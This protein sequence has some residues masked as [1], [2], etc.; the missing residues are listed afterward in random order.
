MPLT[1]SFDWKT[2][3]GINQTFAVDSV[4][5]GKYFNHSLYVSQRC[6]D[7]IVDR[8]RKDLQKRPSVDTRHPDIRLHLHVFDR[9]CNLSIDTSGESLHHRGYRI[10]TNIAPLN[11]VL[12]ACII[13]QS[14]WD[15]SKD[16][17]D[18][19]CGSGTILIE[20][21]MMAAKIPANLNRN[22]FAFEKWID[23]DETLFYK[24]K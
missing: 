6:K 12:A 8:F 4:V 11:E 10:V 14:G 16:F 17:L 15:G 13:K 19:M 1:P 20:A 2:I 21:A 23:W 5:F 18:P 7:A 3:M 22:E 9:K 24:I